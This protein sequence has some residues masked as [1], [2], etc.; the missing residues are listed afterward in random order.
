MVRV[1]QWRRQ[2]LNLPSRQG[3]PGFQLLISICKLEFHYQGQ[4]LSLVFLEVN[5]LLFLSEKMPARYASLNNYRF[6]VETVC[7]EQK[8]QVQL[9][10]MP[11]AS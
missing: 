3:T 8:P 10:Q 6:Q 2:L 5:S 1:P 4:I 9:L 11:S 7:R